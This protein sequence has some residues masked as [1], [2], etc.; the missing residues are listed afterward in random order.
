MYKINRFLCLKQKKNYNGFKFD[1]EQK[2][3]SPKKFISTR[4]DEQ[5]KKK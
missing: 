2:I 5:L 3:K 1:K 4:K